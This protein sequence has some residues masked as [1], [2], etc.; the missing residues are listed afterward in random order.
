MTRL[1]LLADNLDG[2]LGAAVDAHRGWFD[3]QGWSVDVESLGVARARDVVG[4]A[5][6]VGRVRRLARAASVVHCHGLRSFA[7]ARAAG[8]RPFVTVHGA[9]R[10]PS[11]P[12]GNHAVRRLGLGVAARLSAAAITA[13]P[14]MDGGWRF[15]PHASPRLASLDRLPFPEG[16][17]PVI[18]WVGRLDEPKRPLDF[19]HEVAM[20][21]RDRPVEAIIAGHGPMAG[22][23]RRQA[24]AL[25]APVRFAGWLDDPVPVL[26]EA[27]A[28][29]LYSEYEAVPFA[30]QEAMWA[31]RAVTGSSL[32]GVR[33]LAGDDLPPV[34]ALLDRA[35]AMSAG[36]AAASRVRS[37]LR[38]DDPW[39]AVAELYE[40]RGR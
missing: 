31:G 19:V 12:P 28:V 8:A 30:L 38:Q 7:V 21:A 39:P 9:G 36:E 20:L 23:V 16:D 1:L 24:M 15:L 29:V 13:V 25:E 3:S 5:R 26:R 27:W 37:L 40:A 2:G 35:V 14:E 10:V 4:M 32:P 18:A 11:D 6:A 17:V 33:W 34:A 22:L